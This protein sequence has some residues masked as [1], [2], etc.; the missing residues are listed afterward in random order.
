MVHLGKAMGADSR[1]FL[2]TAGI[3]DLVATATSSLSRNFTLGKRLGQGEKLEAI[4]AD[5]TEVA[6]G[7]RTIQIM[8]Q[9][10]RHYSLHIPITE[11][12]FRIV[13]EGFDPFRAIDFLMNYPHAVDVDFL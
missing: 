1:A 12:L 8:R 5:M 2:G 4:L 10:G 11:M 6:E 13:F 9:L 7:V 3:G